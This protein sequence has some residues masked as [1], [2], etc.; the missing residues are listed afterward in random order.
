MNAR[1]LI[2]IVLAGLLAWSGP[3]LADR[4]A[5]EIVDD[6]ALTAKVKVEIARSEG[7]GEAAA[8]NVDTHSRQVSLAGFVDSEA[9]KQ[10]AEAAARR[11]DGVGKVINNLQIKPK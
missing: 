8:V 2:P 3:V 9:Q 5:G 1:P 7:L 10:A 11:V 6:A 4:S